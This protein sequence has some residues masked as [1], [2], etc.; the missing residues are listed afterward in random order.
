MMDCGASDV[1]ADIWSTGAFA[2]ESPLRDLLDSDDFTLEQLLSED[3]LLQE[4]RGLD[5][6]LLDYISQEHIV[7]QL[8]QYVI[9][10]LCDDDNNNGD[11]NNNNDHNND[12]NSNSHE[13]SNRDK[14]IHCYV[15]NENSHHDHVDEKKNQNEDMEQTTTLEEVDIRN[16]HTYTNHNDDIHEGQ[17]NEHQN[18][19]ATTLDP[20]EKA[21]VV[22][23]S[24]EQ[25]MT[26]ASS[27]AVKALKEPGKWLFQQLEY[28]SSNTV[29]ESKSVSY[30]NDS[31]MKRIR[32]PYM[33]CEIICSEISDLIN[34]IVEGT[35]D[36]DMVH[37]RFH[38]LGDAIAKDTTTTPNSNSNTNTTDV[39]TAEDYNDANIQKTPPRQRIRILDILFSLL[40]DTKIGSLDDHRAG[41][42]DKVLSILFRKRPIA[43]SEYFN[44]GDNIIS[45]S[46]GKKYSTNTKLMK[47]FFS[48]LYSHS[49][50]QIVQRLMMPKPQTLQEQAAAIAAAAEERGEIHRQND[51]S[52]GN[53][54]NSQDSDLILSISS[55]DDENDDSFVFQCNWSETELGLQLLLETLITDKK[56]NNNNTT[57]ERCLNATLNASEIIITIIQNSPL[58]SYFMIS[59]TNDPILKTI[60][61][62]AVTLTEEESFSRH[63]ST[64]TSA[65][66]VLESLILQLG[67]YGAVGT[68]SLVQQQQ[69]EEQQSSSSIHTAQQQQNE[70]HITNDRG[71]S[72]NENSKVSSG[73]Q[74]PSTG[75]TN[76]P[77]PIIAGLSTLELYL[78]SLLQSLSLLLADPVT[79][80]WL[81]QMQYSSYALK[82]ANKMSKSSNILKKNINAPQKLLGMS[83]LRIVRLLESLV[84]LGSH[85]VDIY[86]CQSDCLELCLDLFWRFQWCS[87]LHQSVANLL[88]H[89]FEGANKRIQ[90]QEYFLIRCN[91]LGRLMNSFHPQQFGPINDNSTTFE[92]FIGS[93]SS[94]AE[95]DNIQGFS[96]INKEGNIISTADNSLSEV[97]LAV[98]EMSAEVMPTTSSVDTEGGSN[99]DDSNNDNNAM[100]IIAVS[101]DDVDAVLEQQLE[102]QER[103]NENEKVESGE[104]HT[105]EKCDDHEI[106]YNL[107]QQAVT[108]VQNEVIL[109]NDEVEV[110]QVST[111]A[112]QCNDSLEASTD[113]EPYVDDEIP[114][115]SFRYGS[116]GHVIIICQA[117][118]HA[119][120]ATA[121]DTGNC[122]TENNED[123]I[124]HSQ[125]VLELIE[126]VDEQQ[127]YDEDK[128]YEVYNQDSNVQVH[129]TGINDNGNEF[130]CLIV[131]NKAE[132][133]DIIDPDS[134]VE[135]IIENTG[136]DPSAPT[137]NPSLGLAHIVD[138]HPLKLRWQEFIAT[139]LASETAIQSTPLGGFLSNPSMNTGFEGELTIGGLTFGP[140][141][142]S[143]NTDTLQI[144]GGT[145]GGGSNNNRPGLIDDGNYDNDCD[146]DEGDPLQPPPVPPRGIGMLGGGDVIDM[147]DNDLDIAASMMAGL[148]LPGRH[149]HHHHGVSD[150][151]NSTEEH[152]EGNTGSN[153]LNMG[154]SYLFDDPLGK[155]GNLELE[156]G[157]LGRYNLDEKNSNSQDNQG[158]LDK[159]LNSHNIVDDDDDDSDQSSEEEDDPSTLH[160]TKGGGTDEGDHVPVM[161]LFAGNLVG[162]ATNI[163]SAIGDNADCIPSIEANFASFDDAFGTNTT[164]NKAKDDP[165]MGGFS[166]NSN[167]SN[168][169]PAMMVSDFANFDDAFGST[170]PFG[171]TDHNFVTAATRRNSDDSNDNVF[172][173]ATFDDLEQSNFTTST[174]TT[175]TEVVTGTSNDTLPDTFFGGVHSSSFLLE[176]KN[177]VFVDHDKKHDS[178]VSTMLTKAPSTEENTIDTA[179]EVGKQDEEE[180]EEAGIATRKEEIPTEQEETRTKLVPIGDAVH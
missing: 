44:T 176:E 26:T 93:S 36:A 165:F 75:T 162:P 154:S 46:N 117:L 172:F 145:S 177:N 24:N 34:A 25:T 158:K 48:H 137:L 136:G 161:N 18:Q 47:S 51:S 113:D 97:V 155:T 123:Y 29:E 59:L 38:A 141:G 89:I 62:A 132:N 95:A 139:T 128:K 68:V 3:E 40:N 61:D 104:H 171:N 144:L 116:M 147:D 82:V 53:F 175:T 35:V 134:L 148:T 15:G 112:V 131:E 122:S 102:Q 86:L 20:V 54:V 55:S 178:D 79:E 74:T 80:T 179:K 49:I 64:L 76:I 30:E 140:S 114:A 78:P 174:T 94:C 83:R 164:N 90:L 107:E 110:E 108:V 151:A 58:N 65:M 120:T 156:L 100:D 50:M 157:K 10:P 81:S 11:N 180:G 130:G 121:S 27:S 13:D 160:R 98:K 2:M 101:D 17:Q 60:I 99:S 85:R 12:H 33:A 125:N 153:P 9:V 115:Q 41:Y 72:C 118:V 69:E 103:E 159:I 73:S 56:L 19:Q 91:L 126:N 105:D 4:I 129:E 52:G 7:A 166:S 106:K 57:R 152:N 84:L 16:P 111:E 138:S 143:V 21:R 43:L 173:N 5:M 45:T 92:P 39:P 14:D 149:H 109:I 67:G 1:V 37:P 168:A 22:E 163:T 31:D 150:N 119:C 146:G 32:F 63:D 96:I 71:D 167:N 88:V 170:D 127:L 77:V 169:P 133:A 135:S 70:E 42:F 66:N 142:V 6:R 28:G 8:I 23:D 124:N 87:M